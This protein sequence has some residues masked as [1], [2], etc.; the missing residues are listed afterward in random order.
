[1]AKPK[2]LSLDGVRT[3]VTYIKEKLAT[4]VDKEPGKSLSDNNYSDA[5]V[6]KLESIESG[7]QENLIESIRVNGNAQAI[8]QKSVNIAIPLVDATLTNAG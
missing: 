4:K 6:A 5:D 3:L 2:F 8:D 7:A 1:M